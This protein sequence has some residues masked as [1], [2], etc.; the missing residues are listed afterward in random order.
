M[1]LRLQVAF[2]DRVA[3]AVA[4]P[5]GD[6]AAQRV[7]GH[8]VDVLELAAQPGR[9]LV[10]VVEAEAGY[11]IPAIEEGMYNV[12]FVYVGPHDDG[13]SSRSWPCASSTTR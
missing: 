6:L 4:E 8:L 3:V 5:L 10:G 11:Q 13:G 9:E 2:A 12:A 1:L 7:A